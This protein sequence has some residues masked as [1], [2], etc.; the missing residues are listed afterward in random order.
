MIIMTYKICTQKYHTVYYRSEL[1]MPQHKVHGL[2]KSMVWENIST[3][4]SPCFILA[5]YFDIWKYKINNQPESTHEAGL[6]FQE[7]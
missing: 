1:K 7:K 2:P 5:Q 3:A 6:D 4:A